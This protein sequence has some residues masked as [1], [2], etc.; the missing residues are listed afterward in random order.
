MKCLTNRLILIS[1]LS[2]G[3][4][5]P[6]WTAAQMTFNRIVVFGTSISDPG[7]AFALLSQ[8]KIKPPQ[9]HPPYDT[10][11]DLL[12]P[13]APYAIGGHHF[14]NGATWIEQ[15]AKGRGLTADVNAAFKGNSAK[16]AN[17]AVGGARATTPSL[18]AVNLPDQIMAFHTDYPQLPR[19][20]LYVMEMGSNDVRDALIVAVYGCNVP[21]AEGII[22]E[23]LA[24]ISQSLNYLLALGA[25]KFLVVNVPDL[26]LLPS[27]KALPVNPLCP[28]VIPTTAA[29]SLTLKFNTGLDNLIASLPGFQIAKLNTYQKTQDLYNSPQSFGLTNVNDPC[30]T[31]NIPPFTCKTSDTFLFW[32][33]IHPTKVV[34]D[35]FAQEAAIALSLVP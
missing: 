25:Q 22:A 5:A 11:E 27:V 20:A 6:S 19:N 12:I 33:G 30:L 21:A 9:S 17:Y 13:N 14:S 34:H 35:I 24:N 4:L 15:F 16:A 26:A 23:A 32:D 2:V 10:L 8:A 28:L 7:N 31:P 29:R 1:L 3:L 18:G